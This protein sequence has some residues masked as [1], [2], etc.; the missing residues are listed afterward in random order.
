MPA[1]RP[2]APQDPRKAKVL[3]QLRQEMDARFTTVGDAQEGK[4]RLAWFQ[5]RYR[6]L[7]RE[8]GVQP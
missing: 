8:A 2:Q 6:E 3:A 5:A 4:R 7:C 1:K